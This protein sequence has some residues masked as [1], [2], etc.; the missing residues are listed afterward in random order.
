MGALTKCFVERIIAENLSD[1]GYKNCTTFVSN[2]HWSCI[3]Q[4]NVD[5]NSANKLRQF[6]LASA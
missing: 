3:Q 1:K 6:L 2:P 5:G 4:V